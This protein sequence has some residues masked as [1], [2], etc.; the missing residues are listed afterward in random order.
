MDGVQLAL[1]R[2]LAFVCGSARFDSEA[3]FQRLAWELHHVVSKEIAALAILLRRQDGSLCIAK[4]KETE[5]LPP[6]TLLALLMEEKCDSLRC[7]VR[8]HALDTVR[9][10]DSPFRTS[11]LVS[12]K[13]PSV[14]GLGSECVLWSG[15]YGAASR[16]NVEAS[17]SIGNALGEW[18]DVYASVV[19]A[20][21]RSERNKSELQD[22]VSR[23]RGVIHDARAPLGI[24]IYSAREMAGGR[25]GLSTAHQELEYLE[26]L[27]ARGAPK[28]SVLTA[29]ET[30]D[31]GTVFRRVQARLK[32][33]E[34]GSSDIVVRTDY[35]MGRAVIRE[36][37][38]ERVVTNLVGNAMRY[39]PQGKIFL[40]AEPRENFVIIRIKDNG[41]GFPAGIIERVLKGRGV[42]SGGSGWG[43]GLISCK[44]MIESVGGWF[45]IEARI[46]GGSTVSFGL[47]RSFAEVIAEPVMA[48]AERQVPEKMNGGC[49]QIVVVDDDVEH[50]ESLVRI[51]AMRGVAAT[52]FNSI[53]ECLSSGMLST[54]SIVLC[55]AHMPAGGAEKFLSFFIGREDRPFV[56]AI[57]GDVSDELVYRLAALGARGFFGK[58]VAIEEIVDWIE[59][60]RTQSSM[61]RA[62]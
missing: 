54:S 13:L 8:D 3:L 12:V 31:V 20:A 27:L 29:P 17:E 7:R 57:S 42:D 14:L 28:K 1:G 60:A 10:I 5:V 47:L 43:F 61:R 45:D 23:L 26:R 4:S 25:P 18:L 39:A 33:G 34:R 58:P 38:L 41:E 35:E 30:A 21:G 59:H 50:G 37:D 32:E 9:F 19:D 53:S 55:D 22:E 36:I 24:L 11:I 44:A 15:L 6:E 52:Y 40:E 16:A 49:N 48:V 51:L 62:C 2:A 46:E 56:A